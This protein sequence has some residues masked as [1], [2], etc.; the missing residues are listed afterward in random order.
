MSITT[1]TLPRLPVE[2]RTP[3]GGIDPLRT[4][5]ELVDWSRRLTSHLQHMYATLSGG[6]SGSVAVGGAGTIGPVGPQGEQG[7]SGV[8]DI[9]ELQFLRLRVQRVETVLALLGIPVDEF[10]IAP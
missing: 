2:R 1:H 10:P 7:V 8:S 3:A 5:S 6:T 4:V 9:D